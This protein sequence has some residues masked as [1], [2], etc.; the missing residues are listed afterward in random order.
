MSGSRVSVTSGGLS[1]ETGG[2]ERS[3]GNEDRRG[4]RYM[5]GREGF[6]RLSEVNVGTT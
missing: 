3:C 5:T 6:V 1:V 4:G 2:I